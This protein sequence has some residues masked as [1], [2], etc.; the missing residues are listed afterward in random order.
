M[1]IELK[2]ENRPTGTEAITADRLCDAD[3]IVA[4]MKAGKKNTAFVKLWQ[5]GSNEVKLR[6]MV[7]FPE[8]FRLWYRACYAAHMPFLYFNAHQNPVGNRR[9]HRNPLILN[10]LNVGF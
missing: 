8:L 4:R 3:A 9:I 2:R 5:S 1:D 10:F 6:L 7:A